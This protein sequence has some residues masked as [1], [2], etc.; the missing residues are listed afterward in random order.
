MNILGLDIN[1]SEDIC[2]DLNILLCNFHVYY[3][4]LKYSY[5]NIKGENY[6]DLYKIFDNLYKQVDKDIDIIATRI[7]MLEGSV[8]KIFQ[9]YTKFSSLP[10]YNE[11]THKSI[12]DLVNLIISCIKILLRLERLLLIKSDN[13]KDEGTN[14]IISRLIYKKEKNIWILNRWLLR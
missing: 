14:H 2:K 5:W 3:Y 1:K 13:F 11:N 6:F 8:L 9:E 7:L 4:N 10:I 12:I